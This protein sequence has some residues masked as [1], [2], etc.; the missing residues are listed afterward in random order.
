MSFLSIRNRKGERGQTTVEFAL[1]LWPFLMLMFATCDYAQ[2]YFYEN[3]MQAGLREAGRFAGPGKILTY[4]SNG[5]NAPVLSSY[6]AGKPI[7]RNES[8][9]RWFQSN[10]VVGFSSGQILITSGPDDTSMTT[11]GPGDAG[12][13]VQ[14]S[15]T[16]PL[17]LVTPV[18]AMLFPN[19]VYN[20]TVQGVFINEPSNAFVLYTNR[21]PSEP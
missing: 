19:G 4:V 9:R 16:Y 12:D 6:S 3:S 18:S 13:F 14:I 1:I 11:P 15:V 21:Y 20:I 2:L 7:S 8:I 10:C 5:T 17:K